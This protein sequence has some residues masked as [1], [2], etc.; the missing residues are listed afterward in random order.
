MSSLLLQSSLPPCAPEGL[1]L[2]IITHCLQPSRAPHCLKLCISNRVLCSL[3]AGTC[4]GLGHGTHGAPLLGM[5]KTLEETHSTNK[6]LKP[7]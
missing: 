6:E 2:P 5:E 3:F 7:K 4:Q 1:R